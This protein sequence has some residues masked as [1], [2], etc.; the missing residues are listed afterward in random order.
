[1]TDTIPEQV[2]AVL[3]TVESTVHKNH[4]NRGVGNLQHRTLLEFATFIWR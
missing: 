3:S 2:L 1:M 4:C